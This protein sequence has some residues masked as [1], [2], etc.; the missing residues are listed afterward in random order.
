M[1]GE[2]SR[3]R[4]DGY[5]AFNGDSS[6]SL[7]VGQLRPFAP[8]PDPE[9]A[10]SGYLDTVSFGSAHP[11]IIHFAMVDGSVQAISR[12]VDPAVLDR[13][14]Q[15]NDGEVYDFGNAMPTCVTAVSPPPF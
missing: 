13:A 2:I 11:S 10:P 8:F 14:A 12:D 6:P 3:R 5:Q 9:P 7:F 4:A 1:Y 15:R